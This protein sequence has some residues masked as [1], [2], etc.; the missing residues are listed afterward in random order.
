MCARQPKLI[1][2]RRLEGLAGVTDGRPGD[3]RWWGEGEA[4]V[5]VSWAVHANE[6]ALLLVMMG[7]VST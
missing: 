2:A 1:I 5:T 3:P 6:S 4:P 7:K